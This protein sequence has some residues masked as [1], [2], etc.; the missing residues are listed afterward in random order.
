[1]GFEQDPDYD[2]LRGLFKQ[3]M[4]HHNFNYDNDFDWL[5]KGGGPLVNLINLE[6]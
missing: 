2:Y 3:V 5:I 4:G 6:W 1:M